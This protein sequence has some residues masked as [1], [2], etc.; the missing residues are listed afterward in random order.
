M[1]GLQDARH[2]N[3]GRSLFNF[4][5]YHGCENATKIQKIEKEARVILLAHKAHK[6]KAADV[7]CVRDQILSYF[8]E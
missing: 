6:S 8:F 3:R 2:A 5:A 1:F 4:F 7:W